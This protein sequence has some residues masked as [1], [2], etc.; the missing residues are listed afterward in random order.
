MWET[1]GVERERERER[2]MNRGH[3]CS[4]PQTSVSTIVSDWSLAVA[5][6]II[7]FIYCIIAAHRPHVARVALTHTFPTVIYQFVCCFVGFIFFSFSLF[8]FLSFFPALFLLIIISR[9]ITAYIRTHIL[10]LGTIYT[11]RW[12]CEIVSMRHTKHKTI[13][14]NKAIPFIFLIIF[15]SCF[16]LFLSGL[17]PDVLFLML[18]IWFTDRLS[19][20]TSRVQYDL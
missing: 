3:P 16:C 7:L 8:F 17:P 9:L 14:K 13:P 18:K 19:P 10:R 4:L 2:E 15:I 1:W 11:L 12:Q 5:L 6:R 20:C